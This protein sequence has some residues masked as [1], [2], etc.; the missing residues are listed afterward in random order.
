MV[1][2]ISI[3]LLLVSF[4]AK[5][6][7]DLSGAEKFTGKNMYK[8]RSESWT[9]KYS[10]KLEPS[11]YLWYYLFLYKP[12]YKERFPYSTTALVFL[13]DYWHFMQF[14]FLNCLFAGFCLLLPYPI[15]S[16]I[17]VRLIYLISFNYSYENYR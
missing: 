4:Y 1:L 7:M 2:A 11:P 13:T 17:V 15:Y 12:K 9:G 5:G 6:K 3:L 8:N 16:F 10:Y 14:I